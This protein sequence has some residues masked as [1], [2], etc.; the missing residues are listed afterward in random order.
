MA[1]SASEVTILKVGPKP[2][3]P[4]P[5]PAL[6][7]W[8]EKW[9]RSTNITDAFVS[10]RAQQNDHARLPASVWIQNWKLRG[11]EGISDEVASAKRWIEE[12]K[13]KRTPDIY[14]GIKSGES[15]VAFFPMQPRLASELSSEEIPYVLLRPENVIGR[16]K[17][18]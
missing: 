4:K 13:A 17:N 12:W 15:V 7:Q 6:E 8:L 10:K 14:L 5:R 1:D 18:G 16:L 9:K 2:V 11:V 3:I